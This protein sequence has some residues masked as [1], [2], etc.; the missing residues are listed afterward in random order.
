MWDIYI[1]LRNRTQGGFNGREPVEWTNMLAFVELTGVNLSPWDCKL[2]EIIDD[3][4]VH[5]DPEEDEAEDLKTAARLAGTQDVVSSRN[6][7]GIKS[8]LRRHNKRRE[9]NRGRR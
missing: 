3:A 5:P 7:V 8:M 6:A 9:K 2:I 1:R 4:F